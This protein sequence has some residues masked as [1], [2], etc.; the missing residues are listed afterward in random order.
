MEFTFAVWSIQA[1][2]LI[3]CTY[4][5]SLKMKIRPECSGRRGMISFRS[6]PRNNEQ[7]FIVLYIG[8]TTQTRMVEMFKYFQRTGFTMFKMKNL[9]LHAPDSCDFTWPLTDGLECWPPHKFSVISSWI[10][11]LYISLS[12]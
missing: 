5:W 6:L 10:P 7:P 8:S 2:F 1:D 3:P 12:I 9:E 11:L 4:N